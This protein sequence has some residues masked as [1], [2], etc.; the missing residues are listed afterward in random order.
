MEQAGLQI[1]D[2]GL[3]GF[4]YFGTMCLAVRGSVRIEHY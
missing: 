4:G 1:A 3:P 2:N